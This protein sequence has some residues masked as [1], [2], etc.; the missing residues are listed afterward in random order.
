MR[1][2]ALDPEATQPV[3]EGARGRVRMLENLNREFAEKLAGKTIE[4][5]ANEYEFV[6]VIYEPGPADRPESERYNIVLREKGTEILTKVDADT[7]RKDFKV[8]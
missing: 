6:E 3:I 7:F 1:G 4:Y 8:S 2:T 5:W